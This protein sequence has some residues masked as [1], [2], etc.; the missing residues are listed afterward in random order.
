M[1]LIQLF[2][3]LRGQHYVLCIMSHNIFKNVC[4]GHT[5]RAIF[6]A[7]IA[8]LVYQEGTLVNTRHFQNKQVVL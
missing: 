5:F 6:F 3:E 7:E 1:C 2:F 4:A 8:D